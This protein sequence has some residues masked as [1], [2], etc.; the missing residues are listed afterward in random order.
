MRLWKEDVR[1]GSGSDCCRESEQKINLTRL[2]HQNTC[3]GIKLSEEVDENCESFFD[4]LLVCDHDVVN[5]SIKKMDREE[6]EV[7]M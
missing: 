3:R 7:M 5:S 1:E 2:A 6:V 4:L